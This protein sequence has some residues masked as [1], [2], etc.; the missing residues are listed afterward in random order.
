MNKLVLMLAILA[1]FVSTGSSAASLVPSERDCAEILERWAADPDS[2][3]QALVDECKG[4]QGAAGAAGAVAPFV[5]DADAQAAAA[6]A[7]PCAGP[8]AGGS[9]HC[10]GPWAAL[11]P[12]AGSGVEP[13]VLVPVDGYEVRPE[14][15]EQFGPDI[16]SCAPGGP[17]G[18]A[19]IVEGI[20]TEAPADETQ[21]AE[22]DLAVDGTSF[23]V[24]PGQ[25]N[26]IP[27]VT[28]MTPD[29]F[30]RPDDFENM[31]SSGR[32]GDQRSAVVARVVRDGDI[33]QAADIWANANVAAGQGNSG[34]FAWGIAVT[35]ADLDFLRGAG[36]SA[37]FNGQM[38]VDNSTRAAVTVNFA[39]QTT[40][41]GTW[42]NPAYAFD[43]GGT[44][45]GVDMLSDSSQF[46][47][48]VGADSVV[49]GALLGQRD[50]K[51]IAHFIDVNVA[52]VGRI[53]DVG[54]LRE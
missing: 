13:Q 23:V 40:W 30:V 9:A 49:R 17:C 15:A 16:S 32:Q 54:L 37:A 47:N 11:A 36:V 48:N 31:E 51:S 43:A 1:G 3:P 33:N 52:G 45:V 25:P 12:A 34:Y 26:E 18:F 20:T 41:N 35:Q 21:I 44:F 53:K 19:T 7:D 22:F 4:M 10:W 28:N 38:S 29:F 8:D 42:T 24:A 27:S 6:A 39:S 50:A 5:S 2:V 46:S 14:L